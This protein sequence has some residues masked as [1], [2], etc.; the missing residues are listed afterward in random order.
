LPWESTASGDG[1]CDIQ[2]ERASIGC[3]GIQ[4]H[5]GVLSTNLDAHEQSTGSIVDAPHMQTVRVSTVR[6]STVRE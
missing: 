3:M 6:V 1:I 4:T 5:N 2:K